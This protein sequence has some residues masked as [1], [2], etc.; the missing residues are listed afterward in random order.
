MDTPELVLSILKLIEVHGSIS[1]L[2]ATS[3]S[4]VASVPCLDVGGLGCHAWNGEGGWDPSVG[5]G[6]QRQG[7][8][9]IGRTFAWRQLQIYGATLSQARLSSGTTP[10]IHRI[11]NHDSSLL[12]ASQ[13]DAILMCWRKTFTGPSA[14]RNELVVSP[15]PKKVEQIIVILNL[16]MSKWSCDLLSTVF[17][18]LETQTWLN[19]DGRNHQPANVWRATTL[20]FAEQRQVRG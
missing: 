10:T 15:F 19:I 12:S 8:G 4:Q 6:D 1:H 2:P 9:E 14:Q 5:V 17:G 3:V 11:I 7:Q 20:G 13:P 16:I 18:L